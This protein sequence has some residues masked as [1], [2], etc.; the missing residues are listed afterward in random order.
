[1]VQSR[2]HTAFSSAGTWTNSLPSMAGFCYLELLLVKT[3]E[4][5][6]NIPSWKGSTEIKSNNWLHTG[7]PQNSNLMYESIVQT[8]LELRQPGT[9]PTGLLCPTTPGPIGRL[10]CCFSNTLRFCR[11]HCMGRM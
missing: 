6:L 3:H 2:E 9:V 7:H 8:F 10:H 11:N 5:A 4:V 1:M